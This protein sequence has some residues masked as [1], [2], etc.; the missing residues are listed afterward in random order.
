MTNIAKPHGAATVDDE[1]SSGSSNES[2]LTALV[3]RWVAGTKAQA[4]E[5]RETTLRVATPRTE[6]VP[7]AE[8]EEPFDPIEPGEHAADVPG[9]HLANVPGED[10]TSL[11]VP[12]LPR[13]P[14]GTRA[15]QALRIAVLIDARRVSKD[16]ATGLLTRMAERGTVSVCR[17]YADWSRTDLAEWVGQLR[18]Q[19]LH[20]FHQFSDDDDQTLV[21]M[22]IDA[23]DIARDAAFDEVVIAGDMTSM[24]PLVHRLHAAGVRVVVVGPGYTPHDV[25]AACDEFLDA[26]VVG[27]HVVTVGRHRA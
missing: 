5:R 27:G 7:S 15:E 12:H 19:G 13:R 26:D 11:A 14:H 22:A 6:V 18:R 4:G 8:V 9:E 17:A 2:E 20:S 25:R 1:I 21:A 16:V 23:V 3:R 24:L 10:A